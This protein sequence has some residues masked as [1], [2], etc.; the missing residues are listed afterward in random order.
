MLMI[1]VAGGLGVLVGAWPWLWA[2]PWGRLAEHYRLLRAIGQGG[3]D[4]WQI[5]PLRELLIRT[6]PAMLA[7]IPAGV[8][9][10]G[11]WPRARRQWSAGLLLVLWAAVPLLRSA[12]PGYRNYDGIRRFLEVLP[13]LSILAG[14]GLGAIAALVTTR[15]DARAR[16]I[17]RCALVGMAAAHAIWVDVRLHPHQTTYLNRWRGAQAP[18]D[19]WGSSYREAIEWVNLHSE[20][21][22]S[23]VAPVAPWLVEIAAPAWFRPDLR[24]APGWAV[25]PEGP[26][27]API[28]VSRPSIGESRRY[29]IVLNRPGWSEQVRSFLVA[30]ADEVHRIE[31]DGHPI[32]LVFVLSPG[33]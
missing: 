26:G 11:A 18:V 4:L 15:L 3:P 9:G 25:T 6:P 30:N 24:V 5:E 22:A 13:P 8:L 28:E 10:L 2:D 19:Y 7:L 16:R 23:V 33:A 1:M 21:K 12:V 29:V 17:V 31:V 32:V 14:V 27:S 20:P